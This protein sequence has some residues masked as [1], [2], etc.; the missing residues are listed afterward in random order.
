MMRRIDRDGRDRRSAQAHIEGETIGTSDS[1]DN[2]RDVPPAR[3]REGDIIDY[4]TAAAEVV[5]L[6]ERRRPL[7]VLRHPGSHGKTRM[8]DGPVVASADADGPRLRHPDSWCR[9]CAHDLGI[10]PAVV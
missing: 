5:R 6:R 4:V 9:A 1:V 2:Q 10:V 3:P 8:R 7:A